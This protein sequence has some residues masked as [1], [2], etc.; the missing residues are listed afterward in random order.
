M[1]ES[2]RVTIKKKTDHYDIDGDDT[3]EETEKSYIDVCIYWSLVAK[4]RNHDGSCKY[5]N[6]SNFAKMCLI[7]SHGQADIERGFSTNSQIL[8]KTRNRMSYEALN[9]I[10]TLK[11]Y[12]ETH[13][14][15]LQD[16]TATKQMRD[17]HKDAHKNYLIVKQKRKSDVERAA[18]SAKR[19][20]K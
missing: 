8:T 11:N 10:R 6:L 20:Q 19:L 4:L 15:S 5:T 13:G 16:V 18:S 1:I 12:I 3:E 14:G 9:A 17:A 2:S 7:V